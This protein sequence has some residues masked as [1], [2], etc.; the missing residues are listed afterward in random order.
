MALTL[1]GPK[2]KRQQKWGTPKAL[3]AIL[4]EQYHFT[5]N[6]DGSIFDPCP[7]LWDPATHPDG[8]L[9]DWAPSTYVNPPYTGVAAW[10]QKAEA[11]AKKGNRVVMLLNAITDSVWFHEHCYNKPNVSIRFLR[12]RV[13]FV[14]PA[15]PHYRVAN[16][17]PSM[18]VIFEG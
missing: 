5:R 13:P 12:G 8:L 15:N 18:L 6:S 11:E 7:L 9:I 10:V 17:S 3:L 14:D 16:P 4:D 1:T 2:A